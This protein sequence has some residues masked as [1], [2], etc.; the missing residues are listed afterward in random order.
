MRVETSGLYALESP[1]KQKRKKR[2]KALLGT[3]TKRPFFKQETPPALLRTQASFVALLCLLLKK[4]GVRYTSQAAE[5]R[6]DVNTL[7]FVLLRER[8]PIDLV[9][10]YEAFIG[11]ARI[12]QHLF[13][14]MSFH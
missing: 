13:T 4:S 8:V 7:H 14:R 1:S 3:Q 12:H 2:K 5:T 6:K 10:A 11:L 9:G